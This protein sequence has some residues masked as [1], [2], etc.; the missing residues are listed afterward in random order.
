MELKR[1]KKSGR[2][3]ISVRPFYLGDPPAR[4]KSRKELE[5]ERKKRE[6]KKPGRENLPSLAHPVESRGRQEQAE[7]VGIKFVS[8]ADQLEEDFRKGETFFVSLL[9]FLS[10]GVII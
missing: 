6:E 5:E 2:T 10:D 1:C 7:S 8:A 9:L 4:G 3:E